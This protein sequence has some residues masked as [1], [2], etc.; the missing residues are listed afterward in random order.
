MLNFVWQRKNRASLGRTAPPTSLSGCLDDVLG[1]LVDL[2]ENGVGGSESR[3]SCI[4]RTPDLRGSFFR[5]SSSSGSGSGV[6]QSL[7][8]DEVGRPVM[9]ASILSVEHRA[10]HTR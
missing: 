7:S 2:S 5:K 9:T 8:K 1:L 10:H 6:E 3:D 4:V